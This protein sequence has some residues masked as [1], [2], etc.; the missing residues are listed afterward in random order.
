[1]EDKLEKDLTVTWLM[2][3]EKINLQTLFWKK[4]IC[5]AGQITIPYYQVWKNN[6]PKIIYFIQN[7]EHSSSFCNKRCTQHALLHSSKEVLPIESCWLEETHFHEI[8]EK[9]WPEI[10]TVE[11][12]QEGLPMRT[13]NSIKGVTM[14]S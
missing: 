2:M 13:H 11:I 6:W 7:R 1:M 5:I 8:V 14:C 9:A 4:K 10:Q 12:L 3:L